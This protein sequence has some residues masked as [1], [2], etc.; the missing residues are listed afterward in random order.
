MG[1]VHVWACRCYQVMKWN[2]AVSPLVG[3]IMIDTVFYVS[4]SN[5]ANSALFQLLAKIK[6]LTYHH[7]VVLFLF[8]VIKDV[9]STSPHDPC[10]MH[11][12]WRRNSET[13]LLSVL[14]HC[15]YLLSVLIPIVFFLWWK[16]FPLLRIDTVLGLGLKW[17]TV[18]ES[19]KTKRKWWWKRGKQFIR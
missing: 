14:R 13:W 15:C 19:Y 10:M 5:R 7:L 6:T 16:I 8:E 1:P 2:G 4:F 9:N 3:A 12:D 18:L 11:L 17:G